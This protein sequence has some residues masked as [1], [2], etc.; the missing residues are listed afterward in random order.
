MASSQSSI[1][2]SLMPIEGRLTGFGICDAT[3]DVSTEARAVELI[4]IS[5][6]D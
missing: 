5:P 6:E 2:I 1:S 3:G 4:I